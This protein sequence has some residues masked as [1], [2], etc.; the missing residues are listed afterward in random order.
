MHRFLQSLTVF[1]AISKFE[2]LNR[3]LLNLNS[4]V[5]MVKFEFQLNIKS[6]KLY[7]FPTSLKIVAHVSQ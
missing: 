6:T 2:Y 5:E 3:H 7:Y 1:N 4:I